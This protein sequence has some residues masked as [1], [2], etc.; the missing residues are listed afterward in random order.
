MISFCFFGN[1][2]Q[3]NK[4]AQQQQPN[5]QYNTQQ[6][7]SKGMDAQVLLYLKQ[8]VISLEKFHMLISNDQDNQINLRKNHC[9]RCL[10][11]GAKKSNAY[12]GVKGILN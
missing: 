6:Q 9:H 11:Q 5:T 7:H 10:Q 4:P 1:K 8:F 12:T 2:N 3:Q